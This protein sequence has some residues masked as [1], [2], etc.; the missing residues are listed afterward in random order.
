MNAT[1]MHQPTGP[2]TPAAAPRDQLAQMAERFP[3]TIPNH[4]LT[5]AH[6]DGLYRHLVFRTAEG[7]RWL[8]WFDLITWPGALTIN[9]DM[10]C[11]TFARLDDMFEF[12]R[13]DGRLARGVNPHYWSE[14]LRSHNRY[15]PEVRR[16]EPDV[17]RRRV[18][19]HVLDLD[20]GNE[21][22]LHDAAREQLLDDLDDVASNADTAHRALR[23]FEHN[24]HQFHDTWEWDLADWTPQF[25][26]CCHAIVWGIARYDEH[27]ATAGVS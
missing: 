3:T 21:D 10:G 16:H 17:F 12:F 8:Y 26:W 15:S 6:D 13:G 11:Y 1:T 22:G 2:L 23:D 24:G 19:E 4:A 5:V 20:P 25:L 7:P 9:S 14:K 27:R 18:V